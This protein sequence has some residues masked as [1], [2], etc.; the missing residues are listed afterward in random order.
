MSGVLRP[1]DDDLYRHALRGIRRHTGVPLAFAGQVTDRRLVLSHFLGSRSAGLRGLHVEPG[2][3]VGGAVLDRVR[4]HGVADYR[5]ARTITHDYDDPVLAEGIHATIAVP[6]ATHGRV[7]GVLYA[8]VRSGLPLGDRANDVLLRI[9]GRMARE[10]AVRDEVDRRLEL[11]GT[12][13]SGAADQ[14]REL[15]AELAEI[16]AGTPAGP[17]RDRLLRACGRFTPAEPA[18]STLSPRELD[19]LEQVALGCTNA[20]AAERLALKAETVKAYLRSSMAKLGVHNRHQA[21]L[22]ARRL[23]ILR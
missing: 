7:H 8:A 18:E 13:D 14:L 2:K 21:V 1:A 6:V 5:A 11:L 10:L 3:G 16:A 23:G 19:V 22:A 20:E 17:L 4:P 9:A 12:A 15:R